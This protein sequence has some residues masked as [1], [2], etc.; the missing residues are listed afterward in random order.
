[1]SRKNKHKAKSFEQKVKKQNSNLI[2]GDNKWER[3]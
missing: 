1:M 3:L 2:K